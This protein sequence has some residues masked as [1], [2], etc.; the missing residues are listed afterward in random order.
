MCKDEIL[1]LLLNLIATGG[2][3]SVL[4]TW[5]E[6]SDAT[7]YSPAGPYDVLADNLIQIVP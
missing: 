7:L 4:L 3:Q 1:A 2:N 5:D 6:V